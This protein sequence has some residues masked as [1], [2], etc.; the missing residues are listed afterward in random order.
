MTVLVYRDKVFASDSLYNFNE[1]KIK[2]TKIERLYNGMYYGSAGTIDDRSLKA[3][4]A[5]I[6]VDPKK[7]VLD[8]DF[9]SLKQLRKLDIECSALIIVPE[10]MKLGIDPIFIVECVRLKNDDGDDCCVLSLP[11]KPAAL[12]TGADCARAS[13]KRG[14]TAVEAVMDAIEFDLNCDGPVNVLEIKD[15]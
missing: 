5:K 11:D 12:G 1:V 8:T 13:L 6:E 10:N 2:K 3:L 7:G 9:P 15:E 14:S 4:I